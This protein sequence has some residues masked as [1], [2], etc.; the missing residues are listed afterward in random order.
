Q[1]V[2]HHR[3]ERYSPREGVTA[4]RR[5]SDAARREL[6]AA[7]RARLADKRS[8]FAAELKAL[9]ALSPLKVMARGYSLVYDE[10]ERHLIKSLNEVQLGDLVVVKLADGQLD[11]QVWGMKED[12]KDHGEGRSG[13]GV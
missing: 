6:A 11:C 5:R 8:R 2:L 13:T 1:A 12:A 9:D 3:L 4:A 10:K 7:M